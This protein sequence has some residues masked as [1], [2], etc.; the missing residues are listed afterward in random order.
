MMTSKT[1][2]EYDGNENGK[3]WLIYKYPS[4]LF[5]SGTMLVV[6]QGQEALIFKSKKNCEVYQCGTHVI[7]IEYAPDG[8]G[9]FFSAEIY[10]VNITSKLDMNW[11]TQTPF[12]LEDPKYGLILS[13]RSYG[14]Y[15]LRI[16]NARMFVSELI[17]AVQKGSTIDYIMIASY[18]S[19]LLTSKIKTVISK[20]MIKRQISFL[21]VTAYLDELSEQCQAIITDEF[22]RFGVEIQNFYIASITPRKEEYRLLQRYKQEMA[23]GSNFYETNRSYSVFEEIAKRSEHASFEDAGKGLSMLRNDTYS[24]CCPY[25]KSEIVQGVKFCGNCGRPLIKTC[26]RCDTACKPGQKYCSNCGAEL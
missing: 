16:Q 7:D 2:I 19:A 3:L 10:F 23:L 4:E 9:K 1:T 21:E 22:E 25:C 26:S 20:Y 17:G 13:I 6:K 18:F 11:G 15:G 14:T 24:N 12:Q 8:G 5:L